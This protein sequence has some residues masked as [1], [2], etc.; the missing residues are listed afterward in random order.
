M[1]TSADP[2]K[3]RAPQVFAADDPNVVVAPK[4]APEPDP[5]DPERRVVEE[6]ALRL[7][8]RVD[9]A[10]TW[11]WGSVFVSAALALSSLAL[12]LWFTRFV[13]ITLA[14][15][16]WIGW[17][18]TGL[19][20][21]MAVIAIVA[22]LREL[23][24]LFRLRRIT[25]LRQ[26]ADAAITGD[27]KALATGA[28]RRLK[29]LM[30]GRQELAWGRKRMAEHER[31]IL[32]ASELLRLADRELVVPLDR[33]ARRAVVH[34]AKR[35]ATVTAMSPWALLTT[36]F[37]LLENLAL[38]RRVATIYGGRPGF[39]GSVRLARLVV[40]HIIL[41]GGIALTDDLLHQFLGQDLVRRLSQRLGEG[42]FNGTLTA[43]VGAAALAVCRPLPFLETPEPR[44][45]DIV[46]EV[47][48][49]DAEAGPEKPA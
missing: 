28:V 15:E 37:V 29:V 42:V 23:V 20:G 5:G 26:D 48:K 6:S 44:L 12:T 47:F 14:R 34:S 24:G 18:A 3:P 19:L 4:A 9:I 36:G 1:T 31:D 43:R 38:L 7:P 16:D 2:R 17:L 25:R 10:K 27:N 45:R 49:K 30:A 13:S 22:V 35:V 33:D 46:K 39:T 41:T 32:S 40:T 21:L 11:S 8:T